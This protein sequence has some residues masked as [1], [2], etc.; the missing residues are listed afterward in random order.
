LHSVE[1][2]LRGPRRQLGERVGPIKALEIGKSKMNEQIKLYDPADY[3]GEG[4]KYISWIKQ[5]LKLYKA[6]FHKYT[7]IS[8]N[9]NGLKKQTFEQLEKQRNIMNLFET[10]TFLND[11]RILQNFPEIKRDDIK[12][13][14]NYSN[15]K[16]S[17]VTGN[18]SEIDLEGFIELIL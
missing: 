15:L 12:N 9:K 17:N 1:E 6:M 7:A 4:P 8:K 3:E 16:R 11:F 2:N 13:L 5:Y 14:I 18:N 10:F